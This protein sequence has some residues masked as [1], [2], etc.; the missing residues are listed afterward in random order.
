MVGKNEELSGALRNSLEQPVLNSLLF[1]YKKSRLSRQ[2]LVR[3]SQQSL[4]LW[5][6]TFCFPLLNTCSFALTA[7]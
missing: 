5:L 1:G 2:L 7:A 4:C 6:P 3:K